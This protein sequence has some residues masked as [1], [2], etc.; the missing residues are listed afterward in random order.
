MKKTIIICILFCLAAAFA[1][2]QN[3]AVVKEMSG[4]VEIMAPPRGWTAAQVGM[5]MPLGATISTGFNSRAVLD[6]GN[7]LLTVS[8]LTRMRL[9]ELIEQEGTV[10]TD[11]YL[12]VGKVRAEVKTAAGLRQDFKLRS[13]VSTAAVRGTD[14]GY[15]GYGVEV[16]EGNVVYFNL[17]GQNRSYGGGESGGGTGYNT[18]GSGGDGKEAGAGVNPYTTGPGGSSQSGLS[19]GAPA[20]LTGGI[21]I[22]VD[23]FFEE[24]S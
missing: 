11:L 10:R 18:P 19:G 2:A 17:L 13:P 16:Y 20:I 7:A 6:L 9:E 3:E 22:V 23:P 12:G 1:S 15:D 21:I 5:S 14:L 4:K 24:P 8:P